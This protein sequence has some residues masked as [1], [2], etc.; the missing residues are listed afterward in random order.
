MHGQEHF[1]WIVFVYYSN[2]LVQLCEFCQF[3]GLVIGL[4]RPGRVF[5]PQKSEYLFF[6]IWKFWHLLVFWMVK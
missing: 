5:D 4:D 3:G 6:E 1:Q 2:H